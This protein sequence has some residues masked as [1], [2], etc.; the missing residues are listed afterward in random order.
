MNDQLRYSVPD[1]DF[2]SFLLGSWKRNLT[3]KEFGG[4]F[5]SLRTSNTVI[6]VEEKRDAAAEPN[7]RFL[8]WKMGSSLNEERLRLEM[9]MQFIPDETGVTHLEWLYKGHVCHG[10][11][12]PE[13]SSAVMVFVSPTGTTQTCYHVVDQNTMS[14]CV[15]QVDNR[16][17]PTI[18]YGIMYRISPS[19]Y[20]HTTLEEDEDLDS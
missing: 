10:T 20:D 18:Q 14:V 3:W 9:C 17:P 6:V 7:T 4:S 2:Y 12:Q 19:D 13:S 11:F 15:V 1:G 16:H 8:N 5:S